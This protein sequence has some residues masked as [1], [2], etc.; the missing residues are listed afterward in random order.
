MALDLTGLTNYVRENELQLA[1]SLVF[2][3]KTAQL[4]EAAGNVQVGV[5]SA[6]KINIMETDAVFQAGGSCGFSSSGTTAFT[7]RTLTV[8]KVKVNESICPRTF[9]AKYTQKAL[10]AG[11]TY[12]YM[13]FAEEFTAK[14]IAKIGEALETAIWQGDTASGTANLARFDGLIKLT[15]PSGVLVTGVV[16]GNP[17]GI[18][19]ATGITTANVIGIVDGIYQLIPTSIIDN[20]D[21]VIFCGM[22]TFRKYTVALKN[23]NLFNYAAEAVDFEIIIAG[24]NVKLVAVNG[25]NGT[26]KLWASRLSNLYIGVDL[27]NEEDRFELFY[28]KEADEMR[29]VAEFKYSVN[30]AFPTEVVY[31]ALA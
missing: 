22:D 30:Y 29:F 10:R 16:N 5:K 9:E 31:F 11:S 25:L 20:G 2:K 21:V 6:D 12:D 14:K 7:Q 1:T 26:N 24:T 28:A 15:A 13:P 18:T 23:L 3:P 8:G 17:S 19:V 27:L 4:I